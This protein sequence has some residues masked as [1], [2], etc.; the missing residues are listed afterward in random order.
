MSIKLRTLEL[1]CIRAWLK[2]NVAGDENVKL[3]SANSQASSN[4][5]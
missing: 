3:H 2:A 4:N 1:F 5:A